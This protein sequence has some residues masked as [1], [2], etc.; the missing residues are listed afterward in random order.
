MYIKVFLNKEKFIKYF[1]PVQ[2]DI[3]NMI[4]A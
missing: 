1:I 3:Q 2:N 4:S